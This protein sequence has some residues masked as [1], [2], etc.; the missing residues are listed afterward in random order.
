MKFT[1]IKAFEKHLESSSPNHFAPVYGLFMKDQGDRTW[2]LDRLKLSLLTPASSYTSISSDSGEKGV[3]QELLAPSLF[4]E[5]RVIHFSVDSLPKPKHETVAVLLK[6]LPQEVR[7]IFTGEALLK[8]SPLYKVIE[9]EG[10][11]FETAGEKPW[12]REKSLSEW[13]LHRAHLDRKTVSPGVVN[14]LVK[15]VGGSFALLAGEWEKLVLYAGDRSAIHDADL[16]AVGVLLAQESAWALGDALLARDRKK[17]LES[18]LNSLEQGA[19]VI[20]LLRQ[21]RHQL[22]TALK[23]LLHAEEGSLSLLIEK[24]PYLKGAILEKQLHAAK[25]FGKERLL[26]AVVHLDKSELQ[27][28]DGQDDPELLLTQLIARI[29]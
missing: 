7:C 27:A 15:N 17:A 11:L 26:Q 28:K 1:Q 20:Q 18:A 25:L 5:P 4:C 13:I 14:T 9:T 6:Q 16:A 3:L 8:S 23:T 21:M 29:I 12:E 19:A 24:T 22:L 10:A 2:L